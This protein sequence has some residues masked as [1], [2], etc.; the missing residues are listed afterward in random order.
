MNDVG[1]I[2]RMEGLLN[3]FLFFAYSFVSSL[4]KTRGFHD[5]SA[6]IP[7]YSGYWIHVFLSLSPQASTPSFLDNFCG[8]V[9]TLSL[10][11]T[12]IHTHTH[13]HTHT[14]THT[15]NTFKRTHLTLEYCLLSYTFDKRLRAKIHTHTHVHTYTHTHTHTYTHTH[16]HTH[17]YIHKFSIYIYIFPQPFS[18]I[19]KPEHV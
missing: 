14:H 7:R 3:S 18:R 16:T 1:G 5:D 17:T 10:C 2:P 19:H 13:A 12:H 6:G 8:L 15:H 4:I 9:G 11:H